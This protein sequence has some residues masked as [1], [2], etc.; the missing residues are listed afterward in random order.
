M[1]NKELIELL[2]GSMKYTDYC[3]FVGTAVK[4]GLKT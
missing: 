3:I 4:M 2:D 1:T